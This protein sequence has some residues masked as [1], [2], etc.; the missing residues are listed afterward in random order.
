MYEVIRRNTHVEVKGDIPAD[1]KR[2]LLNKFSIYD[3]PTFSYERMLVEEDDNGVRIFGRITDMEIKSLLNVSP[4]ANLAY[5]DFDDV[6]FNMKNKPRNQDQQHLIDFLSGNLNFKYTRAHPQLLVNI[7][8][9]FGK[10]YCTINTLQSYM[11]RAAIIVPT[12]SL[13][14]NWEEE[15]LKH[16]DILPEEILTLT[17]SKYNDVIGDPEYMDGI[18]IVLIVHATISAIRNAHGNEGVTQLFKSL[19]VG[20]KVF[21]EI[22]KNFRNIVLTDL[23]TDTNKTLYLSATVKRSDVREKKMMDRFLNGMLFFGKDDLDG[24]KEKYIKGIVFKMKTYPVQSERKS[25]ITTRGGMKGLTPSMYAKYISSMRFDAISDILDKA[26]PLFGAKKYTEGRMLIL[27]S[28]NDGQE[29]IKEY[30][31]KNYSK[32]TVKVINAK[33]KDSDRVFNTDIVISSTMLMGTGV[34]IPQLTHLLMLD[35]YA[36]EITAEQIPNRLRRIKEATQIYME[37]YDLTIPES[38]RQFKT[39]YKVLSNQL[40]SILY[41]D[42][43]DRPHITPKN[44]YEFIF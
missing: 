24:S 11:N 43:P 6:H 35:T 4:R 2:N 30:I 8:T 31:E 28:N 38:V 25:F 44:E 22:H 21:D 9:A 19:R 29:K 12:T 27:I 32:F 42:M 41:I 33:T 10:T 7:D 34:N 16:T 13:V 18:K 39:R 5:D 1:R 17:P 3:Q 26:I 36:S 23:Y 15:L 40:G 37:T 14:A 20:T